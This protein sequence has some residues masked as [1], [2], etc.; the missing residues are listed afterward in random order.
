MSAV[1]SNTNSFPQDKGRRIVLFWKGQHMD[2]YLFNRLVPHLRSRGMDDAALERAR[3]R[4]AS[5]DE[6][7]K[8]GLPCPFCSDRGRKGWI[9]AG[10]NENTDEAFEIM[11]CK[12]CGET[13]SLSKP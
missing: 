6:N 5:A 9:V 12:S 4:W 13:I 7:E 3:G 1:V 11:K 2:M 10:F 8:R